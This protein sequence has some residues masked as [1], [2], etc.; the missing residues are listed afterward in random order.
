MTLV[1]QNI[2]KIQE[3]FSDSSIT[4]NFFYITE[5]QRELAEE[6][7]SR[8]Q[9]LLWKD[10]SSGVFSTFLEMA[11]STGGVKESTANIAF[12]LERGSTAS[13]NYYLLYYTPKNYVADGKFREIKIRG[14]NYRISHRVG[15]I[16]D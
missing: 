9:G 13:G 5:P 4:I 10:I 7:N 12:A 6:Y 2:E 16:A 3:S 11:E 15:Y 14:Q 8:Q 1:P